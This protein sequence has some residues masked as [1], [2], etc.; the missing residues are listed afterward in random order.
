MEDLAM[1]LGARGL[2][3]NL[4]PLF[5]L[6]RDLRWTWRLSIRALFSS[7]DPALW[8]SV[9]GNPA[10]FLNRLPPERLSAA[11][12]DP[13]FLAGLYGIASDLALDD[14]A[15]PLH[16]G[17]RGLASRK[18]RIAY[19]SAEFGVTEALP[20]YAGGLGVLAGDVLKSAGDPRLLA[21]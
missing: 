16:P 18:D 13:A 1:D 9:R 17:I 10:A 12:A 6:T 2:P 7:L 14:A 20:I 4:D 3:P 19:F 21:G 5:A 15:E 8:S 11:A